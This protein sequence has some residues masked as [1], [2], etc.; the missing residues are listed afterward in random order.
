M[1]VGIGTIA[2]MKQRVIECQL[3]T[4]FAPEDKMTI[5]GDYGT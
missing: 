4:D 2:A 3:L 1:G 5:V